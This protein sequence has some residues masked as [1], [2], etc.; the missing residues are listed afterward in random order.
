MFLWI[1]HCSSGSLNAVKNWSGGFIIFDIFFKEI[2]DIRSFEEY[3][4]CS[5]R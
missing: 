2:D 4:Y 5:K 3:L 1:L